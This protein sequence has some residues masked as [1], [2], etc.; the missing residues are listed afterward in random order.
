M[1]KT[2]FAVLALPLLLCACDFK[3]LAMPKEVEV[4]TGATY[5]FNLIKLDSK[6]QEW[7]DFSKFLDIGKMISGEGEGEGSSSQN[8]FELL[9]YK[10][11]STDYQQLL[12]HMPLQKIDFNLGDQFSNMDFSKQIQGFNLKED[13]VIP[14]LS[15]LNQE[16]AIDLSNLQKTINSG[17]SF[18]GVS[19]AS[20]TVQFASA[21]YFD[22][23]EYTSGSIEISPVS[24]G[25]LTG[26]VSLCDGDTVISSASFSSNK[27]LIP[28]DGKT[29][30]SAGMKIKFSSPTGTSFKAVVKNGKIHVATGVTIPDGVVTVSNPEV[31]F[32]MALSDNIKQCE[33]N[34]GSMKVEL[35][36]TGWTEN[37]I[38]IYPITISGGL[39]LNIPDNS[40][41]PLTGKTLTPS[42]I[43]A[44]AKV[45]LNLNNKT[46]DFSQP[47][48]L[49]ATLTISKISPT[50]KLPDGYK[51]SITNDTSLAALADYM[52]SITLDKSG[53]DVTV[54][55]TL[56]E[57]NDISLNIKSDFLKMEDP[58]VTK[59]F[60]AGSNAKKEEFRGSA[61][62]THTINES[63]PPVDIKATITLP[64]YTEA[65]G[66]KLI[67]V[68]NVEPD[69]TYTIDIQVDPVFNW[70]E[71][72]VKIKDLD[73]TKVKGIFESNMN[74]G[75]LFKAFGET[76]A[77]TYADK[78]EFAKL[79]LYI[80]AELPDMDFFK[81]ASFGGTI[82]A[83]YGK[84]PADENQQDEAHTKAAGSPEKTLLN[85][86]VTL[87][88]MPELVKDSAGFVTAALPGR[89]ID[90]EQ[91]FNL[92][93]PDNLPEG[94]CLCL[95]YNIG[96]NGANNGEGGAGLPI[97]PDDLKNAS[98]TSI[99]I[100]IVLLLTLQ[101]NVTADIPI[102]LME[103]MKKDD[104]SGTP[105]ERD[106]FKRASK[107][108]MEDYQKY[109]DVVK[110]AELEF[111]K[112]KFPIKSSGGMSLTVD[113]GSGQRTDCVL[114]DDTN[115][116][117]A[118]NPS[119]LLN[120][121][122]LVPS[123]KL[124]IGKGSFG[125]PRDMEM[126]TRLKL[127]VKAEGPI[128]IYPFAGQEAH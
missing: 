93:A 105:Q 72:F 12:M 69:K 83:Y 33:I 89:S 113:W 52:T 54:T 103:I 107:T 128:Q 121:Y 125:L 9:K 65:G 79:P 119:T 77:N 31:S 123:I 45:D 62:E 60:A 108:S 70:T 126:E 100:D 47:P 1:K 53:F 99:S 14:K 23:V 4:K 2:L 22:T 44:T 117:I 90:F 118:V 87:V 58:G 30:K 36:T 34:I 120:T 3:N 25:S 37:T 116:L 91:A 106:L 88:G 35:V 13:I 55:N 18:G 98:S 111:Y 61:P 51:N 114:K 39:D 6:K 92:A 26:S 76:F 10:D 27:A 20:L 112:P 110:S 63:T 17:V 28:L 97:T 73:N 48:K 122:P 19:A 94:S 101:F 86:N 66:E 16:K 68:S 42:A 56:P 67:T 21:D 127:R 82:K 38:D 15:G 29:I 5:E 95:D 124:V 11:G 24:E 57:G 75:E 104:G 102:D 41:Q 85:G 115:A 71:A 8:Q 40:D 64:K 50:V 7:M 59:S 96:L 74:K 84:K 43:K 49:K 78:I 109:I 32:D 80:Y 81:N 46:I